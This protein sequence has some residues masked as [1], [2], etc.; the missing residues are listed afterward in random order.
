MID[1]KFNIVDFL[2]F[3]YSWTI[4]EI[5]AMDVRNIRIL[6]RAILERKDNGE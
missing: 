6:L 2:A 3:R 5:L 4:E 1:N